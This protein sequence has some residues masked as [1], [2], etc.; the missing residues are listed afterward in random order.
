MPRGFKTMAR[1]KLIGGQ[2]RRKRTEIR[3]GNDLRNVGDLIYHL[4]INQQT[5][6]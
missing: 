6:D 5:K 4:A 1:S 3:E 2:L